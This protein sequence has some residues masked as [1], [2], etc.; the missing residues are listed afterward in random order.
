MLYLK[1]KLREL[2]NE[3]VLLKAKDDLKRKMNSHIKLELGLETIY[4]L[5]L[6]IIS[7]LLSYTDTPAETS[8][9]SVFNEGLGLLTLTLLSI[10][11]LLSFNSCISAHCKEITACREHFPLKSRLMAS[12][13][14][15]CES[16][17]RV[18]GI[19]MYFAVPLGLFSLH[20]HLQGEQYPF[21]H[22]ALDLVGHD[23]M[24]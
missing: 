19:V 21:S 1:L 17:T 22:Y 13:Y 6:T 24:L 11:I 8:L 20:R 4:Q 12:L 7:L 15:F 18:L 2:P 5:V 10:S 16:L 9:K 3:K 23:G 14:C